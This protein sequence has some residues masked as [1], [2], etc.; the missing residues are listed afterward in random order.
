[1]EVGVE[2]GVEWRKEKWSEVGYGRLAL[3]S[4]E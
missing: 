2:V 4:V 1:M 3:D